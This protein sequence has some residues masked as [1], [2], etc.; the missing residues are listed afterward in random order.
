MNYWIFQAVPKRYDL[1]KEMEEGNVVTWYATRYRSRMTSGDLVFF[2]LAGPEEIR[3][4]YGWGRLVSRPHREPEWESYAV[5]VRFEK[6]LKPHLTVKEI[7]EHPV[8]ENL[9]I[10]RAPQGTNF[11][12]SDEEGRILMD[13]IRQPEQNPGKKEQP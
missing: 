5:D 9:V 3:G 1:R 10:L 13:L 12:L 7:R 8:L 2:W 6:V 11:L 4:I